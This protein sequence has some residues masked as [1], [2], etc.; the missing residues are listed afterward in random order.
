MRETLTALIES[1]RIAWGFM[2]ILPFVGS[3]E[4]K[5]ERAGLSVAI[6]PLIG[7]ILGGL[8]L[9]FYTLLLPYLPETHLKVLAFVLY[10]WLFG[11]LHFDGFVDTVDAIKAH[12]PE[13][14]EQILKDPHIGGIGAAFLVLI[15]LVSFSGF[16]H[17]ENMAFFLTVPILSRFSVG[18]AMRYFPSLKKEG[19]G[20]HFRQGFKTSHL[21]LSVVFTF[22]LCLLALP[23][24][25]T[26]LLLLLMTLLT[27]LISRT[28]TRKIGGLN[29]DMYGFL[30]VVN[31]AAALTLLLLLEKTL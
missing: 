20:E 31:D 11:A 27:L 9:L 5:L 18:V 1:F 29:G 4:F 10:I 19:L 26:L 2:T 15:L 7:A 23:A 6:Y 3:Q 8:V 21:L 30:I 25:S 16:M 12:R 24:E 22:L 17:L 13:K 28:L 14:I